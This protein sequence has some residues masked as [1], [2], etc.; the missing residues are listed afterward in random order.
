[1]RRRRTAFTRP[2]FEPNIALNYTVGALKITPKLYY[3]LVLK[4]PTAEINGAFAVPL[5]DAGTELDF[6]G[7]VGTYK[8]TAAAAD[9][10]PDVKNWGNYWLLGVSMP[11]QIVE[12]HPETHPRLGLHQRW[13]QLPQAGLRPASPQYRRVGRG[14]VTVSYA[15]TF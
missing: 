2:R 3:D 1:M 9:S 12:G 14:V 13:R 8:W 10:S 7:T 6:A 11:F 4:G 5:K 15:I